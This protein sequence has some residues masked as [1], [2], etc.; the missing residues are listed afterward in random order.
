MYF[1]GT[2]VRYT[3]HITYI[4]IYNEHIF[5]HRAHPGAG[6]LRTII[7]T[8]PV[9][10]TYV[11]ICP[12]QYSNKIPSLKRQCHEIFEWFFFF[13]KSLLLVPLE[14]HWVDFNFCR[15]FM[16]IIEYNGVRCTVELIKRR[17]LKKVLSSYSPYY[18]I[19]E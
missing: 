2:V 10:S 4:H 1:T 3:V 16:E 18:M 14:V 8:K 7:I 13:I 15:I 5:T 11:N 6:T 9:Y 19:K 12:L 17:T